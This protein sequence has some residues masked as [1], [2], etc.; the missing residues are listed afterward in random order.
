MLEVASG[1]VIAFATEPG[2][3]ALGAVSG[4]EGAGSPYTK[5]LVAQLRVPG[6]PIEEIFRRV[7]DDVMQEVP[8]QHPTT[9]FTLSGTFHFIPP[10]APTSDEE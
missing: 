6:L 1:M 2:Q 5:H 3:I 7:R 9:W 4:D 8:Q 10:A